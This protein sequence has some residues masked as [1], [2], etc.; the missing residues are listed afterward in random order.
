MKAYKNGSWVST[1]ISSVEHAPWLFCDAP[2]VFLCTEKDC[3]LIFIIDLIMRPVQKNLKSKVCTLLIS[4]VTTIY[5]LKRYYCKDLHDNLHHY[6][7]IDSLQTRVP[8]CSLIVMN[9]LLSLIRWMVQ[10]CVRLIT[11]KN[12][13]E[14]K[15]EYLFR[16]KRPKCDWNFN[17]WNRLTYLFWHNF[18]PECAHRVF[19]FCKMLLSLIFCVI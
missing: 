3:E 16:E 7:Y 18:L 14:F 11:E 8:I 19:F 2:F 17:F 10:S 12:N 9:L 4:P 13:S 5:D 1:S 6:I 15:W